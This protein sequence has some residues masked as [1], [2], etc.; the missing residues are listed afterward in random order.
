MRIVPLTDRLSVTGQIR[1]EDMPDL[2]ARGFRLVVGNRPDGEEPGQPR[3]AEVEAAATAA[4][5]DYWFQPVTGAV[6]DEQAGT[7][8]IRKLEQ[9]EGP[10]IAHCRSG[11]RTTLLWALGAVATGTHSPAEVVERAA[12]AGYD[13]S[14]YL[15]R[16]AAAMR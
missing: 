4:G 9:T 10:V 2:A 5:L 7:A 15:P 3:A 13:L 11:T 6:I 8:F 1:P 14:P 12:V 16:L